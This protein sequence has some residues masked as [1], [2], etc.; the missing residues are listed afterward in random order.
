[1]KTNWM[2]RV[3][4]ESR[5]RDMDDASELLLTELRRG[6]A[7]VSGT[8]NNEQSRARAYTEAARIRDA[9]IELM[10]QTPIEAS[11]R[12]RI[13]RGLNTLVATIDYVEGQSRHSSDT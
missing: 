8:F 1:M 6:L 4:H 13:E 5:R 11:Q 7:L 3:R 9:V 2:P 10:T 12:T